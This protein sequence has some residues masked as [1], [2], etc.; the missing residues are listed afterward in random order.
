MFLLMWNPPQELED[1]QLRAAVAASEREEERRRQQQ[2]QQSRHGN[3]FTEEERAFA[4]MAAEVS[5]DLEQ[6]LEEGAAAAPR[7]RSVRRVRH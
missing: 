6:G 4:G 3:H 2:Q 1:R 7:G 5:A